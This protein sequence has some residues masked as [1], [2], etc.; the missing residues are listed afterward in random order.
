MVRDM[1]ER[2]GFTNNGTTFATHDVPGITRA[3]IPALVAAG[4]NAINIGVDR[5]SAVPKVPVCYNA[6]GG[7]AFTNECAT[8]LGTGRPPFLWRDLASGTEMVTM[9]CPYGYANM[10]DAWLEK[11]I[12]STVTVPCSAHALALN[13]RHDN[14]G[15]PQ[16]QEVMD[17]YAHLRKMF[18]GAKII[19]STLDDF[20]QE[21][22][23]AK[24][25]MP[26]VTSE[27]GDTW[28]FG[29]PSD[30]LKVSLCRAM[31]RARRQWCMQYKNC[32]ADPA[33]YNFTRLLLNNAEHDRRCLCSWQRTFRL[34]WLHQCRVSSQIGD[35]DNQ[36]RA[37]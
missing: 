37:K 14:D 34:E 3:A 15:P 24:H 20:A 10:E 32:M 2:Y 28:S 7:F 9:Q 23:K 18:P 25:C 8:F 22:Q 33:L 6:S 35:R 29:P 19:A 16:L 13:W 5:A 12:N 26:V 4:V 21:M 31:T 11:W 36:R 1:A 30:P 27:I 17:I